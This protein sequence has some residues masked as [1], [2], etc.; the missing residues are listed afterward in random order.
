MVIAEDIAI[1]KAKEYL[2][3]GKFAGFILEDRVKE[4]EAELAKY[5]EKIN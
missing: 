4:Y 2:K 3:N 5:K 1:A